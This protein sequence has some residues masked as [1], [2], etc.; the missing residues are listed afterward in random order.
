M[1]SLLLPLLLQ[2]TP[3]A[4]IIKGTALP[5]PD[6]DTAA[7]LAPVERMFA[8]LA[9]HDAQAIR[10][11]LRPEGGATV[12]IEQPDGTSTIR[13]LNWDEFTAGIKPGPEKFEERFT[14]PPAV[15]ID[16][17]I[18]M[19]WGAYTFLLD[20]KPH[21]CGVDHFDLIREAGQWKVL[22]VTWSQRTTGCGA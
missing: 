2:V 21:H 4:P 8:G 22:N 14:S 9:A 17:N 18:A 19:V 20:G 13:H 12:A 10:A 11:V 3:V 15:E 6:A 7:V 1:I 16:G 5:P